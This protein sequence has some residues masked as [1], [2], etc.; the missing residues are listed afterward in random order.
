MNP[1]SITS[2]LATAS[3]LVPGM[4]KLLPVQATLWEE[5]VTHSSGD[6]AAGVC[7]HAARRAWPEQKHYQNPLNYSATFILEQ[8]QC[9]RKQ[10]AGWDRVTILFSFLAGK[11]LVG[12][13]RPL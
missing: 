10:V 5:A 11:D 12:T 9:K 4:C 1:G 13:R 3:G 7:V 8:R 6:S 2:L